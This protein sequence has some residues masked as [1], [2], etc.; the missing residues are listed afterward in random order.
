MNIQIHELSSSEYIAVDVLPSHYRYIILF[1]IVFY[2]H[3]ERYVLNIHNSN[4]NN[5]NQGRE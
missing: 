5:N 4:N 2:E 3:D 1:I